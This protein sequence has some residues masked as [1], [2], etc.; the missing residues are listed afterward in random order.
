VI[1]QSWDN[2]ELLVVDNG[3]TDGSLELARMFTD[4]RIRVMQEPL[5]GVSNARNHALAKMRG[6]YFC[7]VDADDR[8][9]VHSLRLRLDLFRRFPEAHF[10][11]GAMEAFDARSGA[12]LWV[13]SPW[14]RGAPREALLRLDG[15]CFAGNTWM[16]KRSPGKAY[17]FQGHMTHSEDQAFFLA[18][19]GQGKYVSTPRVVLQYRTGHPSATQDRLRGHDGYFAL[20]RQM[21]GLRPAASPAQLSHAWSVLRRIMFRDLVKTGHLLQAARMWRRPAPKDPVRS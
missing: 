7:F 11:D 2:W 13:R 17:Q 12:V 1:A 10:A 5:A 4:A 8:L 16:V 14:F 18:I 19:S 15:S 21:R 3:S 9:P 20:Y 6:A